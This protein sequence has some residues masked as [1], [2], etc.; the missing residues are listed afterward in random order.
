MPGEWREYIQR[1]KKELNAVILA[2]Y[3]QLP[4]V[5]DVADFVGD[6]F[7]LARQASQISADVIIS[8]GVQFMAESAKILNPGKKV[9]LPEPGAGCPMA[10][11]I[12]ADDLRHMKAKYPDAAVV[13]YVNSSAEVKAESDICCTSANAVQ[14]VNSIAPGQSIIFVPDR[15]LGR[16]VADQTGRDLILW[17]G[18]C[19]VHDNLPLSSLQAQK[20]LYP[21]A[22][23]VVHPECTAEVIAQADAVCST[24]GMVSWVKESTAGEFIVGTEEG[25]LH[26]LRK[27]CPE[28]N[29]YL[30]RERFIC[31]DMKKI[32]P[33]TL[34]GCLEKQ[35]YEVTVPEKI[36]V[37]AFRSLQRML[38]I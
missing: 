21:R 20:E 31:P 34:T 37:K 12:T 13:C 23:V 35:Q 15:N 4:A 38:E 33:E 32:T 22:Q 10:D 16:Y 7:Q 17:D 29:F 36:R 28:K 25:F 24:G 18:F 2:H 27:A 19:P 3:Y 6:S 11:M 1:K 8:C 26:S 14:V 5:Q 9:L 30:G